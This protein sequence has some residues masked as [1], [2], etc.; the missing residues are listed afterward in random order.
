[1]CDG[2]LSQV[3]LSQVVVSV[4]EILSYVDDLQ[5][6]GEN[7]VDVGVTQ[8]SEVPQHTQLGLML[9]SSMGSL[10]SS[11]A[12]KVVVNLCKG[13]EGEGGAR[14]SCCAKSTLHR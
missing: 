10:V 3:A 11:V 13:N 2:S 4:V 5:P 6:I 12:S 9:W 7:L 8:N 1:L 14:C